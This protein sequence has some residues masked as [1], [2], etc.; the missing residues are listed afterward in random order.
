MKKNM[1][2]LMLS[3]EV[4]AQI[5]L[6]AKRMHLSR[7]A[8]IDRILAETVSYITPEQRVRTLYA[9]MLTQ[10]QTLAEEFRFLTGE[11]ET[12]ITAVSALRYKYNPTIRYRVALY[13]DPGC[14]IGEL[15]MTL[16]TQNAALLEAF[17]EFCRIWT[18]LEISAQ[19]RRILAE[20]SGGVY[21]RVLVPMAADC[22]AEL[23]AT[24]ISN[25]LHALDRG[26]KL[27][28]PLLQEPERAYA[29]LS[30]LYLSG[31]QHG[32]ILL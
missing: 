21:T 16:R 10:M 24:A 14:G 25:Y 13:A 4:V 30:G 3:E 5:D 19:Q 9:Q 11:S 28:L 20:Q 1:Y 27:W 7:S 32:L 12:A 23:L 29:A 22:D 26:F 31:M 2:S 6:R 17:A 8:L 15:R 18:A